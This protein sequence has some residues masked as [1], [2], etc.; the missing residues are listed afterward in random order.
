MTL[1]GDEVDWK[2][3]YTHMCTY[4]TLWLHELISVRSMLVRQCVGVMKLHVSVLHA[5]IRVSVGVTYVA[6]L[7]SYMHGFVFLICSR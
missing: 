1:I 6:K 7:M 4:M 5:R 2:I 3:K